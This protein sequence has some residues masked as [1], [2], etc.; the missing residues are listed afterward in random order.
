MQL[1][2]FP[3]SLIITALVLLPNHFWAQS[4]QAPKTIKTET[5]WSY[6]IQNNQP[7]SNGVKTMLTQFN[8]AGQKKQV[9]TFNDDG[10]T[11]YAYQ[12]KHNLFSQECY[13]TTQEGKR[14]NSQQEEYNAAGDLVKRTR[15]T[16]TGDLLDI[17]AFQYKNGQKS[18]E[19]YFNNKK[20]KVYHIQ[21]SYNKA[22]KNIREI[23]TNFKENE[24][25]IGAIDLNDQGK[26]IAYTQYKASGPL[27]KTV[28]YIRDAQG[29]LT[30]KST[31]SANNKLLTKEIYEYKNNKKQCSIYID[32]GKTLV[33]H[34]VYTYDYYK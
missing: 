7:S 16:A 32:N 21:Y 34:T 29:Q 17:T 27:V 31:Y 20:E 4:T 6:P 30:S 9:I 2:L 8:E 33:E 13:W 10:S 18:F 28:E 12:F 3:Y 22:Q 26:P 23:Y 15:Y 11:A 25:L 19:E 1:L 24:N 14:V 5:R